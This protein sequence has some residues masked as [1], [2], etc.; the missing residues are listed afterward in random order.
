MFRQTR[1]SLST[2][3]SSICTCVM[4][5]VK[6]NIECSLPLKW[7]TSRYFLS[8]L[9]SEL[10]GVGGGG[11]AHKYC[12]TSSGLAL[13]SF[14]LHMVNFKMEKKLCSSILRQQDMLSGEVGRSQQGLCFET[15]AKVAS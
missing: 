8:R 1:L 9:V 12:V 15:Q 13:V 3:G 14:S 6:T 4:S 5:E 11:G 10:R 2:G 7:I